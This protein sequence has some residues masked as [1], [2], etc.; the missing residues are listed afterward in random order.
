MG[1]C[2]FVARISAA[3]SPVSA[4]SSVEESVCDLI[5]EEC[6]HFVLACD[7]VVGDPQRVFDDDGHLLK[8]EDDRAVWATICHPAATG[9]REMLWS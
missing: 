7:E 9:A 6:I 1:L 8:R 2:P 3:D 5:N 4:E